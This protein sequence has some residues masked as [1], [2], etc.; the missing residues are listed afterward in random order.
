[1]VISGHTQHCTNALMPDRAGGQVLVV[2]DHPRHGLRA[3]TLKLDQRSG[4]VLAKS[5]RVLPAWADARAGS[6]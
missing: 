6:S 4:R 1:M 5:A 3:L 2:Q